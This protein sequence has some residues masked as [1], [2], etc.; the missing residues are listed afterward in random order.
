MKIALI[1]PIDC[2]DLVA[3]FNTMYHLV[4]PDIYMLSPVYRNFYREIDGYKILD[5]GAAEGTI[6]DHSELHHIASDLGADE[7]VIPDH[8]GDFYRTVESARSFKNWARPEQY[9]YAG[10][11]QG[12]TASEVMACMNFYDGEEWINR[13][14]VPR[15]L[16]RMIFKA[17]RQEFLS[18]MYMNSRTAARPYRFKDYHCLGASEWIRESAALSENSIIRGM[19]TSLPFSMGLENKSMS[20]GHDYVGRQRDYFNITVPRSSSAWGVINDNIRTYLEWAQCLYIQ[21]ETS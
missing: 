14:H 3:E 5:N 9:I 15:Y 6:F 7:I 1:A 8:I 11:L 4:L 12:Q 10:V 20:F 13:I 16:N 21:P 19:D 17:F 2:L 18:A